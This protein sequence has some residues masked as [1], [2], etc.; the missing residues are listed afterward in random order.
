M[1][2]GS[3]LLIWTYV[4]THHQS[5]FLQALRDEGVDLVV[6]YFQRVSPQ[7]LRLGWDDPRNL[8]SGERLVDSNL[9]AVEACPDWRERLHVI[10][11]YGSTFL[12]R[13]AFHLSRRGVSWVNWCE[14]SRKSLRWYLNFP[15]KRGYAALINRYALGALAI[16]SMARQDFVQWGVKDRLI[17]FLPYS[18]AR[19][20]PAQDAST[21]RPVGSP[22]FVFVGALC[23]RKGVDV[24]LRAF[25][26]VTRDHPAAR[27]RLVGYDE[28]GGTYQR[29]VEQLGIGDAVEFTGSVPAHAVANSLQGCDV[30]VLSSR[31][32]GWGMVVNEAASLGKAL[33][34]TDRCGSAHHLITPDVNGFRVRPG[35]QEALAAAMLRYCREPA[36]AR[37]HGERSLARF[38]DFTPSRNA[39]R[40]RQCLSSLV[41]GEAAGEWEIA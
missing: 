36:L 18:S 38:L 10:P 22:Q 35:S 4:P 14:P 13:L 5:A 16:G 29:L 39:W 32:D 37:L 11:G 6:H 33:I 9:G 24:L 30:L 34:A 26:R 12:L 3:K 15:L 27:L 17:R 7:R 31:F 21:A 25:Q 20:T 2:C 19:L 23:H 41:A 8:P 40:L 28:S 1:S